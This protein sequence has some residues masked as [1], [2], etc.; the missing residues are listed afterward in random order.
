[1]IAERATRRTEAGAKSWGGAPYVFKQKVEADRVPTLLHGVNYT[2]MFLSILRGCMDGWQGTV[3]PHGP[4][5][6]SSVTSDSRP[7]M[8]WGA[9]FPVQHPYSSPSWQTGC[10]D[11]S[12]VS[13]IE[14]SWTLVPDERG[15][16]HWLPRPPIEIREPLHVGGDGFFSTSRSVPSMAASLWRIP[17]DFF[18]RLVGKLRVSTDDPDR[19]DM[20]QY[21]GPNLPLLPMKSSDRVRRLCASCKLPMVIRFQKTNTSQNELSDRP[22]SLTP[23]TTF[24]HRRNPRPARHL[25]RMSPAPAAVCERGR[26]T[27]RP[28]RYR[29]TL[30][31]R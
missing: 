8:Q 19:S 21:Q 13:A 17:F 5:L 22:M 4:A 26:K 1:M 6:P 9:M 18:E 15:G 29:P 24:H 28:R 31:L 30:E 2:R 16:L 11:P 20:F 10:S 23:C 12:K 25:P 7:T 3:A 27:A 14:R